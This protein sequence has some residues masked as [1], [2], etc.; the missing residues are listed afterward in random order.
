MAKWTK[1][2]LIRIEFLG[3]R[4]HGW[5]K[6]PG[7]KTVHLMIDKTVEFVFQ[8]DDF[9]TLGCG[10]TDAKVSADD[11]V[12]ELFCKEEL[13]ESFIEKLNRSLPGDIRAK[14][15]EEVAEDFNILQHPKIKEYHYYFSFGEKMHPFSAPLIVN[16]PKNLDLE[17][18]QKAARMLVGV[19]DFRYF[20][21]KPSE[22]SQL[23]REVLLS[24][25][26]PTNRFEGNFFPEKVYV[27]RIKSKG[28]MRYQVRMLM[29]TLIALGE[30]E[31]SGGEFQDLLIKNGE[32]VRWIAPGS[33]LCLHK[34]IF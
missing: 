22:E 1:Y 17:K 3:F 7:M 28:F 11:F 18:M 34:V 6:Q 31:I 4:Y 30:G 15:I 21:P 12:F 33:G 25:I 16:I 9:K 29:G 20:T 10:R 8:H 5:Q 24:E 26:I 23:E 19:H 2:Y 14:S 27:F 32:Q 13:D